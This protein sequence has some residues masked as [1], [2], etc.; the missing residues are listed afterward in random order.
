A[1]APE[2]AIVTAHVAILAKALRGLN[3]LELG[4][5][6]R[7]ASD[8]ALAAL[9]STAPASITVSDDTAEDAEDAEPATIPV[10]EHPR[11]AHKK[12]PSWRERRKA[13]IGPRPAKARKPAPT[14]KEA[15]AERRPTKP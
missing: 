1:G 5:L 13:P 14:P 9:V 12:P 7:A 10:D 6:A 2:G 8:V 3:D 15:P 4:A 11:R